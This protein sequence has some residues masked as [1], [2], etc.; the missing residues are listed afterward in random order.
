MC[1]GLRSCGA[2]TIALIQVATG[3]LDIYWDAAFHSW[4]VCAGM[5]ILQES[6][7]AFFGGI[8]SFKRG[9]DTVGELL[10]GRRC[11]AVRAL[12]VPKG[13]KG[14]TA[15]EHQK[16]LVKELYDSELVLLFH[17][18]SLSSPLI[19]LLDTSQSGDSDY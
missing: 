15:K 13:K 8:D 18:P 3:Q 4:D 5:V 10:M 9:T 7:G 1:H 11:A 17:V 2:T 12:A 19:L 6:G 16:S 14:T